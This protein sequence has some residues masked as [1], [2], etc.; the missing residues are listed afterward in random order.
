MVKRYN[1]VIIPTPAVNHDAEFVSEFIAGKQETCFV[2]DHATQF[3]HISLYHVYLD[4]ASVKEVADAVQRIAK[5]FAPFTVQ[6]TGYHTVK[7][8]WIDASY[9]LDEPLFKLHRACLEGIAPFR[10]RQKDVVMRE[11]W[12]DSSP[13][14]QENL[15]LYGW[16]EARDLFR[17]HLTLARLKGKVDEDFLEIFP[18]KNFSFEVCKIGL[19]ELGEHGTCRKLLAEYTLSPL[20]I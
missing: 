5:S 16:S 11:D 8:E 3:P 9:V 1:I 20:N 18:E 19:Y 17:P 7:G 10:V 4:E 13:A 12:S 15:E 6:S 2:L 14:R